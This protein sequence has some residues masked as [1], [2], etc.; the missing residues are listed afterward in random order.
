MRRRG[1]LVTVVCSPPFAFAAAAAFAA[2]GEAKA[3]AAVVVKSAAFALHQPQC[4]A[5]TASDD[6]DGL[7]NFRNIRHHDI[8]TKNDV[9]FS[10]LTGKKIM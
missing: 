3:A 5:A 1:F 6:C 8:S 10:L 2:S 4:E 9:L 7:N